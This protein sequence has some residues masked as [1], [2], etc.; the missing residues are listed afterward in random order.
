M[1]YLIEPANPA[2]PE[3]PPMRPKTPEV[4]TAVPWPQYYPLYGVFF[5]PY[6]DDQD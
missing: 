3:D 1:E 2:N 6:D 5:P 4:G